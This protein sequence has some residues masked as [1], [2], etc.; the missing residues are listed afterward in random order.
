ML[1]MLDKFRAA[2]RELEEKMTNSKY[3]TAVVAVDDLKNYC[4]SYF[5]SDNYFVFMI[6]CV[7]YIADIKARGCLLKNGKAGIMF[8]KFRESEKNYVPTSIK[9]RG[10]NLKRWIETGA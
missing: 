5:M 3:K 9:E 10:E 8:T 7:S 1:S 2:G 6:Q 4:E